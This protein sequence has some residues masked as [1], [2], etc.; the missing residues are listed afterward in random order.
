MWH[1]KGPMFD[2]M[3]ETID[4]FDTY[5]EDVR[6]VMTTALDPEHVE[7]SV[8]REGDISGKCFW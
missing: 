5:R 6:E 2:D 3:R 8:D 7:D 1:L 4:Q